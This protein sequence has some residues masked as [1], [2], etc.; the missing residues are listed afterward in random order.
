MQSSNLSVWMN[1]LMLTVDVDMFWKNTKSFRIYMIEFHLTHTRFYLK[2][3]IFYGRKCQNPFI[4]Y[5]NNMTEIWNFLGIFLYHQ[6]G[7][8]PLQLLPRHKHCHDA[9]QINQISKNTW[10][11][12]CVCVFTFYVQYC[13]NNLWDEILYTVWPKLI[14]DSKHYSMC[15]AWKAE[16]KGDERG[17]WKKNHI[18]K[19]RAVK[20][21]CY[22]NF[23]KLIPS[24]HFS[25]SIEWMGWTKRKYN[26][27][28]RFDSKE[29]HHYCS[30]RSAHTNILSSIRT[31][32]ALD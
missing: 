26:M 30:T 21:V 9:S 32:Q 17:E 31:I 23:K 12:V 18:T 14:L 29:I 24:G 3:P 5:L 8:H 16:L 15:T 2:G 6:Y 19:I 20:S 22:W 27:H 4:L 10:T 11:R 28:N 13:S 25:L 1:Q 7:F